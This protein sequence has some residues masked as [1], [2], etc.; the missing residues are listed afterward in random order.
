MLYGFAA[1]WPGGAAPFRRAL[2][3]LILADAL[4]IAIHAGFAA[5]VTAGLIERIPA[6]LNISI[7]RQLPEIYMYL[8]WAACLILLSTT[9]YRFGIPM[10]GYV[11]TIFAMVLADDSLRIHE[12]LGGVLAHTLDLHG[13]FGLRAKDYGELAVFAAMG[14]VSSGLFAMA[15]LRADRRYWPLANRFALVIA[16]LALVGVAADAAHSMTSLLPEGPAR[17]SANHIGAVVE[18]GGEMILSSL[19]VAYSWACFHSLR[20]NAA[21]GAPER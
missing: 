4:F 21:A 2:R 10:F 8:K 11:G 7:D 9:A 3:P 6:K 5:L 13:S 16:A 20:P 1:S 17:S 12:R 15:Y 19:A 14:I 18:D